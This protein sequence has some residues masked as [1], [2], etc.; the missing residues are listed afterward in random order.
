MR[1][2]NIGRGFLTEEPFARLVT[3]M[4]IPVRKGL[5]PVTLLNMANTHNNKRGVTVKVSTRQA[6]GLVSE[7]DM[8]KEKEPVAETQ[9]LAE[10][11]KLLQA[12]ELNGKKSKK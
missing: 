11:S 8:R 12:E 10:H 5:A 1:I 7:A 3:E 6:T 2:T 9:N 4:V